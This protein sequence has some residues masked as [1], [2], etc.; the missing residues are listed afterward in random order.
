MK[1]RVLSVNVSE[2]KGVIKKPVDKI[3][4]KEDYGVVGDAHAGGERQVS[5]LDI[6]DINEMKKY[7]NDLSPGM[8]A[9]NI[10]TEG[11]E[12]S[13]IN[14]GDVIKIGDKVELEVTAIGKTCHDGC[15]ISKIVGKCVMPTRGFFA[16]V[17]KGGIVKVGDQII[18]Q[19]NQN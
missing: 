16:R 10:T 11:I 17:L 5:F 19:S 18:I 2:K 4:L 9:E 12:V 14:V 3:V 1:G 15:A 7:L 8:F 6:K 13:E